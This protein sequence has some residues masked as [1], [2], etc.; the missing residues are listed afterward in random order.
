MATATTAPPKPGPS[1]RLL[2]PD[3]QFWQR[4]SPHHEF[5]LSTVTSVALHILAIAL[6]VIGGWLLF[7]LGWKDPA[8]PVPV[9]AVVIGGG[10]GDPKGSGSGPG[11]GGGGP[12]EENVSKDPPRE[13]LPDVPLKDVDPR[14]FDPVDAPR[15][16]DDNGTRLINPAPDVI[17]A[18]E[19][20]NKDARREMFRPLAGQG[21][22]GQGSDGG[23]D[24]GKDTG[25]GKGT[26]PG[27]SKISQRQ[28]RVL[29]WTMIFNTQNGDDY[30]RQLHSLG[31]ILAYPSPDDPTQ[32]M[33]IRNLG[34]GSFGE[35]EDLSQINRIFWVD[36]KPQ[37]VASLARAIGMRAPAHF[38][39]FFPEELEQK[40]LKM[41]LNYRGKPE[42]SIEETK[43]EVRR[44]GAG[45]EPRVISQ[46]SH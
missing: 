35:V 46:R 19:G 37:S 16:T 27:D 30:L 41:E 28:K 2:P 33:V 26:G 10:G 36:D 9:D 1:G 20:V 25:V 18:L 39:A 24:K 43:F 6:L 7:K 34:R 8:A 22:G 4:Y 11:D 45:Y 14:T 40:L 12:P 29:R 42:D 31:A 21:K 3:E 13:Q 17:K 15:V 38:V 23:R 5:P 44:A 32:Y